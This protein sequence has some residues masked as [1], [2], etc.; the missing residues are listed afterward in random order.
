MSTKFIRLN[1]GWSAG[2]NAPEPSIEVVGRDLLLS[3]YINTVDDERGVLRF[4]N[5]SR[6]H[7]RG[8][9]D[10][11]WYL[12]Q[13]R[14]SKIAPA[15]G[16]FYELKGDLKLDE[17]RAKWETVSREFTGSR[18]FLFYFRDETFECDA[19]EWMFEPSSENAFLKRSL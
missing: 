1:D 5:C 17:C 4:K 15:W 18:H 16:E 2:P 19:D 7:M 14:F 8:T 12:G 13:C 6:Y 11:G 10:H 3:F 9:N